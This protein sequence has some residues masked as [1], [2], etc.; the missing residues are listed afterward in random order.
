MP[1]R[2]AVLQTLP[3]LSLLLARSTGGPAGLGLVL[4]GWSLCLLPRAALLAGLA[5][6]SLR[7]R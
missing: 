7:G 4:V 1:A 6:L 3:E 5:V 2:T